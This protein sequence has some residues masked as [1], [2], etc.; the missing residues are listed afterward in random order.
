MLTISYLNREEESAASYEAAVAVLKSRF[1][2]AAFSKRWEQFGS[3]YERQL[4]WATPTE[5]AC[6]VIG[7]RAVAQILRPLQAATSA[8]SVKSPK[9]NPGNNGKPSSAR[10][11]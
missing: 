8:N 2:H 6:D 10:T 5:A 3:D 1:R 11:R 9:K 7:F 4:V